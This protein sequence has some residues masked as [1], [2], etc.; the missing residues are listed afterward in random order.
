MKFLYLAE[1]NIEAQLIKH[2]LQQQNIKSYISGGN[3]HIA[4]GELPTSEL[5]V[6][7]YVDNNDYEDALVFIKDYKKKIEEQLNTKWSCS[8]CNEASPYS[9][10]TCWN[11]GFDRL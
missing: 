3:L 6:K 4:I 2:K 7:M 1:S 11:C 10:S 9:I 8:E 5:Y